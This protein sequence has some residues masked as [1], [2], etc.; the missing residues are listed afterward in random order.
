[1]RNYTL[2]NYEDKLNHQVIHMDQ[3]VC[4][5]PEFRASHM[6]HDYP[7]RKLQLARAVYKGEMEPSEYIAKLVFQGILSRQGERWQNFGENPED[8]TDVTILC[9][10]LMLKAGFGQAIA[11]GL[12]DTLAA[13]GGHVLKTSAESLKAW[14]EAIPV[15]SGSGNLL[16]LDDATAA[17]AAEAAPVLGQWFKERG[18]SFEPDIEPIFAGFEYFAYGLV[19]EGIDYLKAL[20]EKM[21]DK[22][23]KVVYTLSAQSTYLL[24]TFA[25]KLDIEVPFEVVYLPDEIKALNIDTPSYFYGGSF[26]CRFLGNGQILNALAVNDDEKRVATSME[27]LPLLEADR[28]VNVLNIWQKPLTAEYFL[29]GF[30]EAMAEK[31]QQD[32]LAD[33]EKSGANQIVVFEPY[34]YAL[35]KS[36]LPEKKVLYYLACL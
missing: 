8:A 25:E 1:M 14:Q 29:T 5:C 11:E 27:F 28:R 36:K 13:N 18:I 6:L 17:L 3:A 7:S 32:A 23:V 4:Y 15:L 30:D 20:V 21:H 9:R 2:E 24:T 19:D 31:I 12:K 16:F 26:N 33:I 22:G 34:A 35:L 10:E